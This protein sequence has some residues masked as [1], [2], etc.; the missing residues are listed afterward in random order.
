[1]NSDMAIDI[2]IDSL[3]LFSKSADA[4]REKRHEAACADA[5]ALRVA[6]RYGEQIKAPE[7]TRGLRVL[8]GLAWVSVDGKDHIL[9]EGDCL[10]VS[11]AR[12]GAI[13]SPL[14]AGEI[15]FEI[16]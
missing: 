15:L 6:L 3:T 13:I 1:M 5:P 10:A 4:P 8:S 7:K 16:S 14:R 9:R 2:V 11:G 12:G